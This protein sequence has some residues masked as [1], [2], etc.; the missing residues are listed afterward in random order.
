MNARGAGAK[1]GVSDRLA[2]HRRADRSGIRHALHDAQTNNR[3][4]IF[5]CRDVAGESGLCGRTPALMNHALE[6][7]SRRKIPVWNTA[8]AA[9]CAGA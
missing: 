6:V 1:A 3:W 5:Y 7:A 8:E 2:M 9:L 4:L